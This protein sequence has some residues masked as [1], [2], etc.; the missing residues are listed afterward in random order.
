[1][2]IIDFRLRPAIPAFIDHLNW[3][4]ARH[5]Q[6]SSSHVDATLDRALAPPELISVMDDLGIRLGVFTGRDWYGDDPD[7]PLTNEAIAETAKS[8]S[9]DSSVHPARPGPDY[10][11]QTCRSEL[12]SLRKAARQL[13]PDHR[14]QSRP[15]TRPCRQSPGPCPASAA[16]HRS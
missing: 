12:Q 4:V 7:W 16:I 5:P 14:R 6:K 9:D 2:R 15:A 1:M 13:L 8:F 10:A 3:R 11:A